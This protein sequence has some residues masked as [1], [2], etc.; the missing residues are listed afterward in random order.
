MDWLQQ[1]FAPKQQDSV[2][3]LCFPTSLCHKAGLTSGGQA[4]QDLMTVGTRLWGSWWDGRAL[5][6]VKIYDFAVYMDRQQVPL[7]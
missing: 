4:C 6:R 7:L 2:S 1:R 5:L 3:A